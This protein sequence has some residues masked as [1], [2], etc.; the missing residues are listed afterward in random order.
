MIP[1]F[2]KIRAK[3]VEL[4]RAQEAVDQVFN[5]ILVKQILDGHLIE[6]VAINTTADVDH[7]LGIAP[8]GW[9][10]VRKDANEDVWENTSAVPTRLLSLESTGAVTVSLW[11]F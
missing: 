4:N 8:R 10:V 6:D 2:R 11:V 3:D 7:G 1:R 5:T 9:L